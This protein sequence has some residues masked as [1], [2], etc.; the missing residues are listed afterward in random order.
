MSINRTAPEKYRLQDYI[1]VELLL[2]FGLEEV[3]RC[4]VEPKGGEDASI[5]T[6]EPNARHYE[7]QVKGS[8]DQIT[9][10]EL[11]LWLTHFPEHRDRG[12]AIER[13][14]ADPSR[15]FLIVGSGR[16]SNDLDPLVAPPDWAGADRPLPSTALANKLL[17][18]FAESKIEGSAKGA[19]AHRRG[20]HHA[21]T[22]E[23]LNIAEIRMLLQRVIIIEKAVESSVVAQIEQALR[24]KGVPDD[25]VSDAVWHLLSTISQRRKNGE[26]V[27]GP[28]A[29]QIL[30]DTPASI[31]PREYVS[32]DNEAAWSKILTE[33]NC[34]LFS[35]VTRS[36]K[37]SAAKWIAADFQH[38]GAE[39]RQFSSFESAERFILE[40]AMGSRLALVDDPLGGNHGV[41]DPAREL[42]RLESLI[43]RLSPGRRLIVAQ[44]RERLLEIGGVVDLESLVT[45]GQNWI[46]TGT[47]SNGL[48]ARIWL[49]A[50]TGSHVSEPFKSEM[51]D[52]IRRGNVHL[53][54]GTLAFVANRPDVIAGNLSVTQAVALGGMD[55]ADLGRA[56]KAEAR[57][58]LLLGALALA[59][60]PRE[61]ASWTDIAFL[62]GAGGEV[63]PS[64]AQVSWMI[65]SYGGSKKAPA[66]L[67]Q[68][69]G[70]PWPD[71]NAIADLDKLELRRMLATDT[72]YR[73]NFTHPFY[74]AA[75]ESTL[76]A[77]SQR[78]LDQWLAAH[79]RALFSRTPATTRAAARNLD[80]LV[81]TWKNNAN[82]RA[83]LFEHAKEGLRS[84]FPATRDLCFDFI[85]RHLAEATPKD[86][87]ILQM[88]VDA[89][90]SG[91]LDTIQWLDGEPMFSVDGHATSERIF[92][93]DAPQK[94]EVAS[95]L[96]AIEESS[97][98]SISAEKAA[99]AVIYLEQHPEEMSHRQIG[100][101]LS[102][103]VAIMRAEASKVWLA[104]DRAKDE[105]LLQRIFSDGH[106]LV[107]NS[108]LEGAIASEGKI[109]HARRERVMAG[110]KA[111]AEEAA[112]AALFLARLIE[113]EYDGDG[114][115]LRPWSFI[116]SLLPTVL[117]SLPVE[118]SFVEA[119]FYEA[120][121]A[122]TSKLPPESIAAICN[123]WIGWVERSD[124]AC[125]PLDDYSLG[126][127]EILLGL[128][129]DNIGLRDGMIARLLK[130]E[131]TGS[132]LHVISDAI[133]QWNDLTNEERSL[134]I[135]RLLAPGIDRRWRQAAALTRSVVP[136]EI[137]AALLPAGITLA[138]DA[139]SLRNSISA[140]LFAD[141]VAFACGY[142]DRLNEW[143]P[144]DINP[145]WRAIVDAIARDPQDPLFPAAFERAAERHSIV[146][147]N[148]A[149]IFAILL[150]E[151]ADADADAVFP[152][153][154]ERS[155]YD[156]GLAHAAN[157]Q[158]LLTIGPRD[159]NRGHWYD[160][161]ADAAPVI[162]DHIDRMDK[163]LSDP[164]HRSEIERRL[165][166]D[167]GALTALNTI[168]DLTDHWTKIKHAEEAG[169]GSDRDL[170]RNRLLSALAE[171][172]V[173]TLE[174]D[175]PRFL[176]TIELVR[177]YLGDQQLL[178]DEQKERIAAVRSKA[179]DKLQELR[180]EHAQSRN[181]P[182]PVDWNPPFV[183][184]PRIKFG[185]SDPTLL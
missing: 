111:F 40:E 23:L 153:L 25:R 16:A 135:Q 96:S 55:A 57:S 172:T 114:T 105:P 51:A 70:N 89:V 104:V 160:Q 185:V 84:L 2:R 44:G 88:S 113:R 156:G 69:E 158:I 165:V 171:A 78:T 9:L 163:W 138:D 176:D 147:E 174:K 54:A 177:D 148:G 34:L 59:S 149:S 21:A 123:S 184:I 181:V 109:S 20:E 11:A 38:H 18:A 8:E 136:P 35:G 36:G 79:R 47:R 7:V 133:R 122:A 155:I 180:H 1:C 76:R 157:W 43:P 86:G 161:M 144:L 126:V 129:G 42:S 3:A 182:D 81:E 77:P 142:P 71:D 102:Y 46:D 28:I 173:L 179:V 150:A 94:Q 58:P 119:R 132:V 92:P 110:L 90:T 134:L 108:A 82:A 65:L 30:R 107:A 124:T 99:D 145:H 62:C 139:V 49:A 4:V 41:V 37:S 143:R 118:A 85:I 127:T 66:P 87:N 31:R 52:Q 32:G 140:E 12:M 125:R 10:A 151:V 168:S 13:L 72:E 98:P 19:L 27:A 128:K 63:L 64:L 80:W 22:A 67:P 152:F 73:S 15:Y 120:V 178:D 29:V 45:G 154:L 26:D 112:N 83:K 167:T 116:Q 103:E 170:D 117:D 24:L 68:Y 50:A 56:L 61:P 60:S 130:L 33:R 166:S 146:D 75:A 137:E 5:V 53:D 106:P 48:L 6:R 93:W 91:R 131:V 95:I 101:L 162:A 169:D 97:S 100:Y 17:I 141:C 121:E 14:L 115:A 164:E 39:V 74:R 183:R 159:G 175:P